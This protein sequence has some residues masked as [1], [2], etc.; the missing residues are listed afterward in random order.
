MWDC[1]RMWSGSREMENTDAFQELH[2][3]NQFLAQFPNKTMHTH[4]KLHCD[5]DHE[6]FSFLD[7]Y[8]HLYHSP[9]CLSSPRLLS[10]Q[11]SDISAFSATLGSHHDSL[12]DAEIIT[13]SFSLL[14]LICHRTSYNEFTFY[15]RTKHAREGVF[16]ASGVIFRTKRHVLRPLHLSSSARLICFKLPFASVENHLI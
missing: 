16:K 4:L 8:L 15:L 6:Y 14:R 5:I 3:T 1:K 2:C 13:P 7:V 11:P 10:T 9:S 12:M